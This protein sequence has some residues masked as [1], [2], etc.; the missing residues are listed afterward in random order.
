MDIWRKEILGELIIHFKD[1]EPCEHKGCIAHTSHPCE[2]CGRINAKGEITI[3][4]FKYD[5]LINKY[6]RQKNKI[7]V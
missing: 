3:N 7:N 6:N 5:N 2:V 1:L 4:R